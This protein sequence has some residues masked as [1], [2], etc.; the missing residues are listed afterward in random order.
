METVVLVLLCIAIAV[1]GAVMCVLIAVAAAVVCM[2]LWA[3]VK[4]SISA[5]I[6]RWM[7]WF[8]RRT[9]C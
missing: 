9:S 3:L 2:T 8:D 4:P 1:I 6:D 7:D 5:L